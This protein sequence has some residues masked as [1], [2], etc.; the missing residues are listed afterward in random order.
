MDPIP[1]RLVAPITSLLVAGVPVAAKDRG[2]RVVGMRARTPSTIRD[3]RLLKL[4]LDRRAR[5]DATGTGS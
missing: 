2:A 1:L 3:G 4:H 5:E